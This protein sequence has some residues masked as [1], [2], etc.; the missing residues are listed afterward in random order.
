LRLKHFSATYPVQFPKG[1]G[2]MDTIETVRWIVIAITLIA[3]YIVGY[4]AFYQWSGRSGGYSQEGKI[5]A[6]SFWPIIGLGFSALYVGSFL[7]FLWRM[8][9]KSVSWRYFKGLSLPIM[10]LFQKG[11][12]IGNFLADRDD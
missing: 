6:G 4:G 3:I 11:V 7:Y 1:E 10:F 9:Q 12:A 8:A 2:K 5:V